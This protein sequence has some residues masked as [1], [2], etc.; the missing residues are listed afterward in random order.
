MK[1]FLTLLLILSA[2]ALT[3]QTTTTT[4]TPLIKLAWES[5]TRTQ[6]I[7]G[8]ASWCEPSHDGLLS[9]AYARSGTTSLRFQIDDTDPNCTG[10]MRT[11]TYNRN[12]KVMGY[13]NTIA[14]SELIPTNMAYDII[15]ELHFQMHDSGALGSPLWGL[16]VY[17]DRYYLGT[18]VYDEVLNTCTQKKWD[19]GPVTKG[20]WVD[21]IVVQKF[22]LDATGNL[23]VFKNGVLAM[24][25]LQL[26]N[27]SLAAAAP[28]DIK[29]ANFNR[30]A[31]GRRDG[32]PYPKFGIYKW[33]WT[34]KTGYPTGAPHTVT[35]KVVYMDDVKFGD[36]TVPLSQFLYTTPITNT[37]TKT[38][39]SCSGGNDA[40]A[41][42]NVSGGT[43]PYTYTWNTSPAQ[44]A[45]TATGLAAGTYNIIAKDAAGNTTSASVT[46]TQP[47]PVLI[48]ANAAPVLVYGDSTAVSLAATGGTAPYTFTGSTS[49]IAGTYLY[50]V[51]DAKGCSAS[52]TLIVAQPAVLT[53]T[54]AAS[55]IKCFGSSSTVTVSASGGVAP[56]T[57]TGIFSVT[58]GTYSYLVKDNNGAISI[59]S[60]TLTQPAMINTATV[61][62]IK[63]PTCVMPAGSVELN[64]LP[65]A[66]TW[67]LTR[68]PDSANTSGTGN[69]ITITNLAPGR[70]YA[71]MV[72]N[73]DGC[74]STPT[75]DITIDTVVA[76]QTPVIVSVTQPAC[77]T[78]TGS[79]VV[80]GLP[81][82]GQWTLTTT[83][84]GVPSITGTGTTQTV[85]GLPAGAVYNFSVTSDAGCT[86][87][88]SADVVLTSASANATAPV[89]GS[90]T[91]PNCTVATGSV[92]LIGLPSSGTWTL[93]R[94]PGSYVSTVTGTSKTIS[95]LAAGITYN[96][97]LTSADGCSSSPSADIVINASPKPA[98]KAVG[99]TAGNTLNSCGATVTLGSNLTIG[100]SVA[101]V[102]TY[103]IGTASIASPYS[104]PVGTSTV[105]A[106]A[107]NTCGSV[108]AN[109]TVIVTDDQAPVITSAATFV[110]NVS[111]GMYSVSGKEFDAT[112]TDNCGIASLY[113]GLSGATV[114]ASSTNN[115]TLN[116]VKL[117]KGIT[118][119][120][121]TATDVNGKKS[122]SIV[123]VTIT[124]SQSSTKRTAASTTTTTAS[125]PDVAIQAP[126]ELMTATSNNISMVNDVKLKTMNTSKTPLALDVKAMPNQTSNVFTLQLK[127]GSEDQ[128][129]IIVTDAAGRI[130]EQKNNIASNSMLQLGSGYRAGVYFALILQQQENVVVKLIKQ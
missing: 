120:T 102:V 80:G 28:M 71:Y 78:S 128:I 103:K 9:T 49:V 77:N 13:N 117:N 91:Q 116:A 90:I 61:N 56:Y 68:L 59:A 6:G 104:F 54:V 98:V 63:H 35:S 109:F 16:E 118:T 47:S 42:V 33:Q 34:P 106:T 18:N 21:W 11:E 26:S 127:G 93:T 51:K 32:V 25:Q 29:G 114:L 58:A 84:A 7:L 64:N 75:Q 107:T 30:L 15:P 38:T 27:G 5:G 110:K 23:K 41:T 53:A 48:T 96:Y 45:K 66:G 86:S 83:A 69:S 65:G 24:G 123:T 101:S 79:V 88:Y 62:S 105:T 36:S 67:K 12:M 82:M 111:A 74:T 19:L 129:K 121:W 115:K 60:V 57:G 95:G 10:H 55:A 81:T 70:T 8:T 99:L 43:A 14:W 94:M 3:A 89:I 97:T 108:A 119:I 92:V 126:Q 87:S 85:T 22:R 4:T 31:N 44:Y 130:I 50:S 122:T 20:V 2:T 113:Y 72:T 39:V 73:S 125:V 37:V 1:Q 52:T 17:K 76:P 124:S 46:I 100:G 40:T 112:A